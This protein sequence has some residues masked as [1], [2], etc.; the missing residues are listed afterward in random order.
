MSKDSRHRAV[1]TG[2]ITSDVHPGWAFDWVTDLPREYNLDGLRVVDQCSAGFGWAEPDPDPLPR[3]AYSGHRAGTCFEVESTELREACID[4]IHELLGTDDVLHEVRH[5][6]NGY[7]TDLVFA[8]LDA[9]G[10]RTRLAR[11]VGHF[12]LHDPYQRFQVWWYVR[13]YGP[14][15]RAKAVE[16][17]K[18]SDP[19]KNRRHVEWLLDHGHLAR[20]S[21]GVLVAVEPPRIAELHAVELKL[22]DW[23]KALEQAERANRCER[24]R[25]D[26]GYTNYAA[27]NP[28]WR[29]RYGYADYRWVAMDAGGIDR[30]LDNREAFEESGVGLLAVAEGGTVIK[31]V[32]AENEPRDR[33]TRD[34]AYAESCLWGRLDPDEYRVESADAV[35]A[36]SE[37][38]S[39]RMYTDGGDA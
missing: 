14:M 1:R 20:T 26:R 21:T 29:D 17:G 31:H 6:H 25:E 24:S 7:H 36:E 8:D 39:L 28:G 34:R 2:W 35:G 22:R 15:P 33:Y 16:E 37:P 9:G 12:P 4:P 30:A 13:E 11:E 38:A 23:E 19:A 18:Y 27:R 5:Q 32:G 10:I 3:S